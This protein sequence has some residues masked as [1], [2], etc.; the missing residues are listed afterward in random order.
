MEDDRAQADLG[1]AIDTEVDL[2]TRKEAK[3][4]KKR[5]IGRKAAAENAER[6]GHSNVAIEEGNA[7]QGLPFRLC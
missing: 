2:N 5:F 4:P 7:V 1:K 6:L 3:Q